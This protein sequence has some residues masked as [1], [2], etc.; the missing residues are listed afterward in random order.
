MS[1]GSL[2]CNYKAIQLSNALVAIVNSD[3]LG[4][5]NINSVAKT[6]TLVGSGTYDWPGNSVDYYLAFQVDNYVREYLVTSRTD[7]V[8]TYA[9]GGGFSATATNQTW[10]LRGYPKG[11]VLNLLNYSI[12]YEISGPTL[13]V[14][15]N[16]DSGEVGA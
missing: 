3:L 15:N 10:V 8:L 7:D 1:A 5:I 12:N 11:D 16:A 9:D 4:T 2:R 6:A 14:Y 13:G